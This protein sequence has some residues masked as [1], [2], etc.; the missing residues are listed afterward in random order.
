MKTKPTEE[1]RNMPTYTTREEFNDNFLFPVITNAYKHLMPG[2]HFALNV[3]QDMYADVRKVLGAAGKKYPLAIKSRYSGQAPVYK[4]YIYVWKKTGSGLK[5]GGD[6]I[7]MKLTPIEKVGDN[8]AKRDDLFEYKGQRGGKVRSALYLMRKHSSPGY[9]T[10]GNRNSPQINIVSAIA[11][12]MGKPIIG[13]TATGELGP[14]VEAAKMKGADIQQVRPGY[15]SV[16]AARAKTAAEKKGYYYVPFGMD[17]DE[18]HHL[19]ANQVRNVPKEVKRIIVPLGSA[20]S[21]IGILKGVEEHRPDLKVVGVRVGANPAR[22]L[23]K[24]FPDWRKYGS[25][26]N[27]KTEYSDPVPVDKAYLGSIPLDPF[28]EAKVLPFVKKG[29]L[30]WIVGHREIRGSGDAED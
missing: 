12:S 3:P 28:Y 29:D 15:E 6:D 24:Y 10:A 5:G 26:V 25:I 1:Y 7:L 27:A 17:T 13:F 18:V 22:K 9:T 21:F 23:K 8:W 2:G 19:V 20:S 14:E 16:V 4:E 30:V 11:K